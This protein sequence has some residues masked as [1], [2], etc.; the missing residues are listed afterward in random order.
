MASLLHIQVSPS[1]AY[2]VSRSI[3][4]AFTE[5]WSAA[6][7]GGKIIDKDLVEN[8]IPHL[9]GE[10]IYANYVPAEQQSDKMKEKHAYRLA[11]IAEITG[12]DEILISTPMWNWSIPS[13]LKA[14]IDQIVLTG[15]LDGSG[16]SGLSGK[17]ITFVVS[18]GGSYKAGTP[19]AG[20][21]LATKY[22]ELVA[23]ALGATDVQT[24]LA[25]FT[26]AGVAPGMEAFIQA[27]EA[28]IAEATDKAVK[29]AG[30]K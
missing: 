8:P 29:R 15:V 5:S 3:A 12:V 27:K 13:V 24:I 17:K 18:Q 4:D 30:L 21:D 22:L 25:E 9:D 11:L 19:K 1:G 26:L 14:Y 16:N 20:W 28:S 7:P 23:K 10:A 2:S 6:N